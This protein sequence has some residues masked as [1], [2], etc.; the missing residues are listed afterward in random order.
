MTFSV[1]KSVSSLW[2]IAEPEMRERIE[3]MAVA[4]ARAALEDT[5]LKHCS[6]TRVSEKGVTRPLEADL[7]G[8][9]FV[10]GTS[11]ENDPQLHVHCTMFNLARTREDGKWRAHHQYPVYSWKKAAGAS[12]RA[13]LAWELQQGLGV[14]IVPRPAP[15]AA[16]RRPRLRPCRLDDDASA[17]APEQ[18]CAGD[19][20]RGRLGLG[21]AGLRH[22]RPDHRAGEDRPG[23]PGAGYADRAL[24]AHG[25]C[26]L[27]GRADTG[28]RDRRHAPR[29]L[30]DTVMVPEHELTVGILVII[31]ADL[32]S[33]DPG[34]WRPGE[35]RHSSPGL[36]MR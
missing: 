1:D 12:F 18:V 33:G 17:P 30:A 21:F 2:A 16:A 26:G 4:S 31:A 11:R 13:Y 5:V 22:G 20:E 29:A 19:A 8:A 3:A 9:T 27:R 14:R 10:H 28:G 35:A 7:M 25:R 32:L 36:A 34:G 15:R 24:D 23:S 6:C